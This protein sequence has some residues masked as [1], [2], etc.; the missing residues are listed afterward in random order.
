LSLILILEDA[1]PVILQFISITGLY[2]EVDIKY[3]G[4]GRMKHQTR[5]FLFIILLILNPLSLSA[6][7]IDVNGSWSETINVN[8]L[9]AG[10]GSD[11][12][13]TYTSPADQA[14][15][16]ITLTS[17]ALDEWRVDVKK[18]DSNWHSSTHLYL[19]R[20]SDGTPGHIGATISGGTSY[21]EVT[22]IDQVFFSGSGDRLNVGIQLRLTGFSVHVPPGNYSTTI[23]LT[24]VDT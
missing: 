10:A 14:T 8:D 24:F 4:H 13:S 15:V 6:G 3:E 5:A 9:I 23:I 21:L 19:R 20:S 1:S 12:N 11:V 7:S 22:D 2:D 16:D 18:S 17:G